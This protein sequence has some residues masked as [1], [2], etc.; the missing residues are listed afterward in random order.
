MLLD[1]RAEPRVAPHQNAPRPLDLG[2]GERERHGNT[3]SWS[4]D[5]GLGDRLG[6]CTSRIVSRA[7][8]KLDF[9]RMQEQGRQ[10]IMV[11]RTL[12][13]ALCGVALLVSASLAQAQERATLT[14]KSGEQV[15]GQ[16]VDL[17]AAGFTVTVDGQ[18]RQIPRGQVAVITF[19]GGEMSSGDWAGYDGKPQVVLRNGQTIKGRLSDI[20]GTKPLRV[21][22][23]TGSGTRDIP[24]NQIARVILARPATAAAEG[25]G[26]M[27]GTTTNQAVP[28]SGEGRT[29]T[30]PAT[31]RWTATGIRVTRGQTIHFDSS[32]QVRMSV[33]PGDMAVPK[34]SLMRRNAKSAPL[35]Q[36]PA[37]ALI[38]RIGSGQP[39][40]IG[41]QKTIV[42]P[43]SGD[44]FLGVNDDELGDNEGSYQ[45]T[46][47]VTGR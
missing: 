35:P 31:S 18:E 46:V 6:L 47:R 22:I 1:E 37:G 14:L 11:K 27:G 20:G 16:L 32:G 10:I 2:L 43:A 9:V 3:L 29:V 40:L 21:T 7:R 45:V 41:D 5:D 26:D 44:L 39:F 42:A 12:L 19:A 23:E 4:P 8:A 25:A 24:S 33:N 28:R 36:A 30:V 17:G 13:A 15:T 34:G 38:G